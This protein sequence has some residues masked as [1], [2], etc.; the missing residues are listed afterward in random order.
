MTGAEFKTKFEV[1]IDE[2]Y[3]GYW[4]DDRLN[5]IAETAIN[6]VTTNILKDFQSNDLDT[7]RILPLLNSATI[8]N[9]V[10]NNIDISPTSVQVVKCKQ[11]LFIEPTFNSTQTTVRTTEVMYADF[12]SIYDTG[13]VRYPNYLLSNGT[14]NIYPKSTAVTSCTVYYVREP[15]YIDV[16]DNVDVLP[17]ND[18]ML[19]LVIRETVKEASLSTREYTMSQVSSQIVNTETK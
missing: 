5:V 12:G 15:F 4:P 2:E 19:Q 11:V 7:A 3:S 14:I 16:A 8:V 9:P 17:Y 13:T 6:T 1:L 10:N 18:E